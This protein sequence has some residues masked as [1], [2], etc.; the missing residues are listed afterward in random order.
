MEKANLKG[1]SFAL[2]FFIMLLIFGWDTVNVGGQ[3]TTKVYVDPVMSTAMPG[4]RF[5]VDINIADVTDLWAFNLKLMWN[6]DVLNVTKITEGSFLNA[7]EKYNTFFVPK[8]DFPE[9]GSLQ[10]G[11]TLSGE[12]SAAVAS[13]SGTLVTVEFIVNEEGATPL[14]LYD[15]ELLNYDLYKMP[16]TTEDGSFKYPVSEI[17]VNPPSISDPS[18]TVGNTFNINI[19]I[20]GAKEIYA[21]SFNMSW[22][23]AIL[24]VTGIDEGTFLNQEGTYNTTFTTN[25]EEGFIYANCTL[26][27]EPPAASAS[28]NGRL[29]SITFLVKAIGS[30]LLH[31]DNAVLLNYDGVTVIPITKDGYFSSILR[32]VAIIS[33]K[34][35][36]NEVKTGDSVSISVV[37]KNEGATTFDRS[38]DISIYYNNSF[39]GT[40]G[41]PDLNPGAEDTLT[42]NWSTKDL[43]EG[44]YSIK[45]VASQIFGETDTENNV[46]IYEYLVVIAPE[47]SFPFTLVII[48]AIAIVVGIVGFI[49]VRKRH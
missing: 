14:Q 20:T 6:P 28:G 3:V 17:S 31:F 4:E 1:K 42:F 7:E 12:P 19:S 47:Q 8:K 24:N 45:A 13:G 21:W 29:A 11:C 40:L 23:N 39:L 32:D 26:S 15:T 10:V 30:T 9:K 33:V 44:K 37:A 36:P 2:V 22:D 35:A 38:V 25:E 43:S 34:V 27:G 49:F 48:I 46:Y 16:H 41:I 18:L 5:T